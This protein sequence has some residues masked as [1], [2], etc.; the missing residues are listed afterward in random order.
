MF[1]SIHD[2]YIIMKYIILGLF[3]I[4]LVQFRGLDIDL[5]EI[6]I[7]H[8][9][10]L[11]VLSNPLAK[12][13]IGILGRYLEQVVKLTDNPR[14]GL[15]SGFRIPFML[16]RTFFNAYPKFKTVAEFFEKAELRDSSSSLTT[17]NT[18]V[19]G[20]Y[21]HYNIISIPEFRE[22]YPVAARQ[23]TEMQYG[24]ALQCAYSYTGRFLVP[25]TAFS[26]YG[27]SGQRDLLEEYLNC[28]VEFNQ[29]KSTL[30]FDKSILDLPIINPKKDLFP[31]FENMMGE[32]E[33][34]QNKDN[35]S[36]AVRRYLMHSLST[37]AFNLQPVAERF[38][39]SERNIQR[40]LKAEG[41]SYQQILD[42]LRMELAQ[43]Y[44]KERIPLV[45]IA[46]LLGFESQSAFNKFFN[47]HFHT[48]PGQFK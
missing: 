12:I 32:M 10:D 25:V 23:W 14:I 13:D 37:F 41:T 4:F 31:I 20:D 16:T 44:L 21:F 5:N 29:E 46:F 9:T 42:N 27:K 43:K 33:Y 18:Y 15:E 11:N 30:I 1:L 38:H 34:K 36:G 2:K 28:P 35:L 19:E 39:M 17:Y 24:V 7:E 3:N 8:K 48:T 26:I 22:R 45:E 47:K 6:F 40:K